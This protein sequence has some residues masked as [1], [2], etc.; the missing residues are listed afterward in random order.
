MISDGDRG[1]AGRQE[2]RKAGIQ[3]RRA[4]KAGRKAERQGLLA[5]VVATLI[6]V[7]R[8]GRLRKDATQLLRF[9]S[10]PS[11]I[12]ARAKTRIPDGVEA[13]FGF[14]SFLEHDSELCCELF[15]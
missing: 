15:V 3:G 10:Q 5:P 11:G 2:G 4:G 13:P 1:K 14:V 6:I 8:T 9:S 7:C 12:V